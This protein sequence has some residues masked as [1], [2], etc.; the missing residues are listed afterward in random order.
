LKNNNLNGKIIQILYIDNKINLKNFKNNDDVM[1]FKNTVNLF[2]NEIYNRNERI[3]LDFEIVE[4]E[5]NLIS[6]IEQAIDLLNLFLAFVKS[7]SFYRIIELTME[8]EVIYKKI[9]EIY[10]L[11]IKNKNSFKDFYFIYM[12]KYLILE[13]FNTSFDFDRDILLSNDMYEQLNQDFNQNKFLII[14]KEDKHFKIIRSSKD[15]IKYLGLNLESIFPKIIQ[16]PLLL[17]FQNTLRE[18]EKLDF[19]FTFIANVDTEH[20]KNDSSLKDKKI[21]EE[22]KHE[23]KKNEKFDLESQTANENLNILDLGNINYKSNL[24]ISKINNDNKIL[25]EG[26]GESL[27]FAKF[28]CKILPSL[29]INELIINCCYRFLEE[30]ILI[31]DYNHFTKTESLL[32]ISDNLAQRLEINNEIL[33]LYKN[34]NIKFYDIFKEVSNN[35]SENDH[36]VSDINKNKTEH[37]N[38]NKL[39]ERNQTLYSSSNI[40]SE[41]GY[42]NLILQKKNSH[43]FNFNYL[44]YKRIYENLMLRL[45]EMVLEYYKNIRRLLKKILETM[46]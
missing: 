44:E 24:Q 43:M 25:K 7:E 14:K 26:K 18:S 9:L 21:K 37:M 20:I 3:Y 15:F 40:T 45:N 35:F 30:E 13:I 16:I 5:T 22:K 10:K 4:I 2:V 19:K 46:T 32:C 41:R 23:N 33:N 1:F 17:D 39:L 8:M 36:I 34:N 38:T 42:I 12:V 27:I 6:K 11:I 29:N 28:N 31:F